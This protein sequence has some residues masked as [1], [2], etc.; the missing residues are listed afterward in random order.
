MAKAPSIRELRKAAGY[1]RDALGL[2]EW[3]L[4]VFY[5]KPITGCDPSLANGEIA[6]DCEGQAEWH[7][8]ETQAFIALRRG[9]ATV[10]TVVH[11]LLHIR[12]EGHRP[13]PLK[14]DPLYER[15]LNVLAA[16]LLK[17]KEQ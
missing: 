12:L 9:K 17:P 5:G 4:Y 6:D 13:A 10:E 11:E 14:Y 2:N 15:A 8:E 16:A 1:W 7:T 3:T